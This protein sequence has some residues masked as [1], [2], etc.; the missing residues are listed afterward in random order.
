MRKTL[1]TSIAV[2]VLIEVPAQMQRID[3]FVEQLKK[4]T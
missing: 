2:L 1:L 4:E 3:N